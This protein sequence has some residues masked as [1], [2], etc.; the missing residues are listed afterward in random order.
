MVFEEVLQA[1]PQM[2]VVSDEPLMA[3]GWFRGIMLRKI[4]E[5]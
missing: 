5:Y 1:V 2:E 4:T 3:N